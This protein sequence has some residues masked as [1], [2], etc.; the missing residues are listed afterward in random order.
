[1]VD[2]DE[3]QETEHIEIN[4]EDEQIIAVD[5]DD[6]VSRDE[7]QR[8]DKSRNEDDAPQPTQ[9]NENCTICMDEWTVGGDHRVC[10][11]NCGHL[12]G[13]KCIEQWIKEKGGQ[14]KCP[15]CNKAAKKTHIR[16]LWVK[17]IK[18]I[19]NNEALELS[20]QLERERK[21]RKT[22]DALLYNQRIKIEML[23]EDV[24]KLKKAVIERDQTI[25]KMR[26]AMAQTIKRRKIDDRV[27]DSEDEISMPEMIEIESENINQFREIKGVFH[28]AKKFESSRNGG[29][30]SM[31][32]SPSAGII[33]VSQPA[34]SG[35]IFDEFG[36]KKYSLLDENLKEFIPLHKKNITAM[37]LR[38]AGDLVLTAASDKRVRIT[39]MH[40]NI[41]IHT[42]L[43][44]FEPVGLAWSAHRENQFYVATGNRFAQLYDMRNTSEHIC[45]SSC[46]V[47]ESRPLS[48]AA[49]NE[50][51]GI[52]I[53]DIR[54]SQFIDVSQESDYNESYIN[55]EIEHF[56]HHSLPFNGLM[57][58][59]DYDSS[60]KLALISSRS[61]Q[62]IPNSTHHLV[63]LHKTNHPDTQETV[64]NCNQGKIFQGGKASDLLS[65][66]RILTHP[67]L[68]D[69]V[70]VGA[71][72]GDAK[73]I[74]LWDSSDSS[75]FQTIR[76]DQFIRDMTMYTPQNS[77][78]HLLYALGDKNINIYRWDYA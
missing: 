71:W 76:T 66:S 58:T 7:V 19:D 30:R 20:K 35:S 55:R 75:L 38:K 68:E 70:L 73:G 61:S 11:L 25:S 78:Q 43:T 13:R 26:I 77:N 21:N 40:N 46:R 15:I 36:L 1:M 53:N 3:D 31:A 51:E 29:C 8:N 42:Y 41:C 37:D 27:Y 12:F 10:C 24:C 67:T 47:S 18:A 63:Q 59:V 54:G 48:I 4:V 52:L 57:G 14:A 28:A 34:S 49:S 44:T 32:I 65:H 45:Q 6:D 74:K 72:D 56:K 64:I 39:S 16:D 22:D 17:S 2:E 60:K 33:I 9:D 69:C 23:E 50:P 62:N 5:I